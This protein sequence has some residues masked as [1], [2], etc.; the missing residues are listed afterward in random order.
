MI[1]TIPPFSGDDSPDAVSWLDFHIA[2]EHIELHNFNRKD[3]VI[4]FLNKIKDPAKRVITTKDKE[5]SV[6]EIFNKLKAIHG[7]QNHK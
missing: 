5:T 4:Q 6:Q 3:S 7:T 1:E 2:V